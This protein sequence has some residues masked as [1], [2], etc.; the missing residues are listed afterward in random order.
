MTVTEQQARALAYMLHEIRPDWGAASLVSLIGK[1]HDSVP[2]IGALILAATTKAMEPS[3]KTPGPIFHPGPHWRTEDAAERFLPTPPAC[4]DHET[5][6]AHNCP[7]CWADHKVGQR[8]AT[9]I[10][11]HY[12]PE[13]ETTA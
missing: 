8:P 4:E 12:T 1:H 3:C 9:H 10:G 11:K 7:C 5:F 6:A 2:S 13:S